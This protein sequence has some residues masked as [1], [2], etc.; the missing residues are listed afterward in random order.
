MHNMLAILIDKK[1]YLRF[2]CN[3]SNPNNFAVILFIVHKPIFGP[4]A[5]AVATKLPPSRW[6][7]PWL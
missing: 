1:S 5:V 3:S 7:N 2:Y 6:H 4:Y